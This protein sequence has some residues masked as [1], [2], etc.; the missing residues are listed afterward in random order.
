MVLGVEMGQIADQ[1]LDHWQMG[2]RVE[3]MA[4]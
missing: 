3:R 1:I 2:Q 4:P